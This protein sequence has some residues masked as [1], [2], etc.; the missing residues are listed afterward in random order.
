[1]DDLGFANEKAEAF[2]KIWR[3]EARATFSDL[4]DQPHL[5]DFAWEL[6]LQTLSSKDASGIVPNVRLKLGLANGDAT[7]RENV[8]FELHND[9]MLMLYNSLEAIQ[10]KLDYIQNATK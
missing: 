4:K 6:N 10:N 8:T 9:E 1:M 3:N 5:D 7:R 2:V